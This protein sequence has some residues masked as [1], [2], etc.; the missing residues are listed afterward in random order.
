MTDLFTKWVIAE[1]LKSKTAAEVA[2]VVLDKLFDFGIVE[3][4]ITDQGREFVNQVIT[5]SNKVLH[6]LM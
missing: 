1:P 6:C 5:I 3:R 2:A 4:I